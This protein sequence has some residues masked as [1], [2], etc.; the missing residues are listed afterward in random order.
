MQVL[1]SAVTMSMEGSRAGVQTRLIE[2]LGNTSMSTITLS[3]GRAQVHSGANSPMTLSKP[4]VTLSPFKY[5]PTFI[6]QV[7][8]VLCTHLPPKLSGPQVPLC[9]NSRA[10]L[11]TMTAAMNPWGLF[12]LL[13]LN[14]A[15]AVVL[16][17]FYAQ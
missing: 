5:S 6:I 12:R 15:L 14:T 3:Q 9:R 2:S 11:F 8:H 7:I 4:P 17:T 1:T 10:T 13:F 16:S